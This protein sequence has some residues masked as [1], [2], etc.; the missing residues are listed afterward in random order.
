MYVTQVYLCKNA[1][2]SNYYLVSANVVHFLCSLTIK[3]EKEEMKKRD[4]F[5]IMRY[6]S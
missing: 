6:Y 3:M 1:T 5:Q 2:I 4:I